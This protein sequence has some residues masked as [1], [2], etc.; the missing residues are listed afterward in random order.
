MA[1]L[2]GGRCSNCR[3][4]YLI[5]IRD[6]GSISIQE[7]GRSYDY[8]PG[9]NHAAIVPDYIRRRGAYEPGG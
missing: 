8:C 4:R 5:Y 3:R 7:A 1:K 2:L 9:C 6:D